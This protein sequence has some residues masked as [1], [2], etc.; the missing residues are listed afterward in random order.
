MRKP[1]SGAG[2]MLVSKDHRSMERLVRSLLG[3]RRTL[4]PERRDA[5]LRIS[6]AHTCTV[7]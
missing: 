3:R 2:S 4:A 7:T 1:A 5:H 6:I